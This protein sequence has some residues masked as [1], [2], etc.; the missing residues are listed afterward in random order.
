MDNNDLYWGLYKEHV[1]QAR[2]HEDHR[3]RASALILALAGAAVAFIAN[4]GL[5][6]ID[7]FMS[8]PLIP[9]G[10][11]GVRFAYK[12]YERNR[13]HVRIASAYL[14]HINPDIYQIRR[15][16]ENEHKEKYP[17]SNKWSLHRHWEAL[18]LVVSFLGVVISVAILWI[19]G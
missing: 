3:E 16:A 15:E 10:L 19:K 7:L 5:D 8:V 14:K 4:D 18:H 12:H 1:V 6:Y 11:F 9:L 17:R 13:M 2:Q